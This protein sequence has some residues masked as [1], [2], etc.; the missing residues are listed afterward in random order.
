MFR[1]RV[2]QVDQS[3]IF[4]LTGPNGQEISAT[5]KYPEQLTE[6]Y[7]NWQLLYR[8]RYELQS[9]ARV[10][11]KGGS[12]TPRS[13]DWDRELRI[14]ETTL[15]NEFSHWLGQA[16]LLL[17]RE[18]IQW[19][20]DAAIKQV[21]HGKTAIPSHVDVLI[22]CS[23]TTLARFP[24]ES[25]KLIPKDAPTETVRIA[26]T[27]TP[28]IPA[29]YSR[30]RQGKIRILAI[31]AAAPD[32]NHSLD[33]AALLSLAPR[34]EIKFIRCQEILS[35]LKR[36]SHIAELKQ[37][38]AK[39]IADEQGWDIFIFSGHSDEEVIT[40]G[41][42]ELAPQVTL[43]ISEI[44]PQ[45]QIAK[46]QGLQ[47]AIF[48]SCSGLHIAESLIR[49]GLPQVVVMRER[50]QDEVAHKFLQQFCHS[51]N[52]YNDV[53]TAVLR[54]CQYFAPENISYPSAHLVPSLFRHPDPKLNLFRLEPSSLKRIWQQWRP[55][56]WEAIAISTIS[57]LSLMVP[58][59]ELLMDVRYWSQAIYRQTTK[60]FPATTSPSVTL[61]Q[62]DQASIDRRGIDAYKIKPMSRAYLG[63]LVERLQQLQV[64]VIGIDYLLDAST[65]EDYVLAKAMQSAI[66]QQTLFVMASWQNDAGQK[67]R[68]ASTLAKSNLVLHGDVGITG[69]DI[70]LPSQIGCQEECP[71]AYQLALAYQLQ[72][73][74]PSSQFSGD[75]MSDLQNRIN[76]QLEAAENTKQIGD[77]QKQVNLPLGLKSVIDFSLPPQRVFHSQPAWDLLER[78]LED[79]KSK[80]LRQQVVIIASGGYDQA[81]DNFP[82]P[83]AMHHWQSAKKQAGI[84]QEKLQS[85]IL[86]GGVLHAYT[87]HH[88]LTNHN[89]LQIP[90]IFFVGVAAIAGKGLQRIIRN[91]STAR[92]RRSLA[93]ILGATLAYGLGGLQTYVSLAIILPWFLPSVVVWFYL[94][95]VLKRKK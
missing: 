12:G 25:W 48:N 44:E 26:R 52:G 51:L 17:I 77:L 93:L 73:I 69:W 29:T 67:M 88:L 74:H 90:T 16:D 53:C 38:V 47:L 79:A 82:M 2:R 81:D 68:T 87:V 63:E 34:A 32:L 33:Q 41:K 66:Q 65:N 37:Q 7:Q 36:G 84:N 50:I 71:F 21:K 92:Q 42:L 85:Q 31:L 5:I 15:L 46:E 18:T 1:L 20:A 6:L 10:S 62:I 76:A 58:V 72:K 56:R 24:W 55:S 3:C 23:P 83:L 27:C 39:A 45:L 95:L 14:A 61:L 40:G 43:S 75:F 13:Y 11:S 4:D 30:F 64:K 89:L 60:Q 19:E 49:L 91:Q 54:A 22:E 59:Q 8:R 86:P 35:T 70:M 78:P 80:D 28:S 94:C 57:V 9:R